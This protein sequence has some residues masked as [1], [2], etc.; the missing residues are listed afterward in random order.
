MKWKRLLYFFRVGIW[1]SSLSKYPLPKRVL[2]DMLRKTFLAIRFFVGRGHGEY[3][4]SLS[5]STI[6]AVVPIAAVAFAV[7]KGFGL[8]HY[9]MEWVRGVLSSQPQVAEWIITMGDSY[10]NHAR[11][12]VILG[13]GIVF[14]LYS[15]ISLVNH[16]EHVFNEIWQVKKDRPVMQLI[17]TYTSMI[18]LFPIVIII[19][20]GVNLYVYAF[21]DSLQSYRLLGWV[22]QLLIKLV[23]L[24]LMVIAFLFLFIFTPNT[25]VR[26][27]HA[28]GPSVLAAVAMLALQFVYINSQVFLSSYNAI[29]GSFAALPLFMLWVMASWYICLFCA[30]M[31]YASQNLDYYTYLVGTDG[32]CHRSKLVVSA[33]LLGH[34]GRAF[35]E[36]R[37]PLTALQLRQL[38]GIPIRVVSDLLY[39]MCELGFIVENNGAD[40]ELV[41]TYQPAQ[42]LRHLTVGRLFQALTSHRDALRH[43]DVSLAQQVS[44]VALQLLE[45]AENECYEQLEALSILDFVNMSEEKDNS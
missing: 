26:V 21:V 7:G 19:L 43:V 42:S 41:P 12:G 28:V 25:G 14:M 9:L 17:V 35:D 3:A 31:C 15:V 37:P 36:A 38:T 24:L 6:L 39:K 20:S 32:L 16:V 2:I 44:A 18:F 30:E 34:I 10:L 22:V 40:G 33:I 13:V 29:Y 11:T 8:S 27:R 4:T 5:F 45:H 23:P 1:K